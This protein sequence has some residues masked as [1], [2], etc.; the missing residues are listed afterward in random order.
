MHLEMAPS[1]IPRMASQT[2]RFDS[3]FWTLVAASWAVG[4]KKVEIHH[5]RGV[6]L[7]RHRHPVNGKLGHTYP[8]RVRRIEKCKYSRL[9]DI[10]QTKSDIY[11]LIGE[12]KAMLDWARPSKVDHA[13]RATVQARQ[14]PGRLCLEEEM[15]WN[16]FPP[17]HP[18]RRLTLV[19]VD[20]RRQNLGAPDQ[21]FDIRRTALVLPRHLPDVIHNPFQP[22]PVYF[23]LSAWSPKTEARWR[24]PKD[25]QG[26]C[27]TGRVVQSGRQWSSESEDSLRLRCS[28]IIPSIGSRRRVVV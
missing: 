11:R 10:C 26:I 16:Q 7:G 17:L 5:W 6:P 23:G 27:R 12:G 13:R 3:F 21:R 18:S 1:P 22:L 2:A 28:Q 24:D 15:W 20:E 4:A 14:S 9:W 8:N 25:C 19:V